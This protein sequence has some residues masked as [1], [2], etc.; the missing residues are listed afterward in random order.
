MQLPSRNQALPAAPLTQRRFAVGATELLFLV[1]LIGICAALIG[2]AVSWRPPI[3]VGV[4]SE[5]LGG[6]AF[7]DGIYPREQHPSGFYYRWTNGASLVQL[8][9]AANYASAYRVVV[10]LRSDRPGDPVPLSLR[11]DTREL[12]TASPGPALRSYQLLLAPAADGE[13]RLNLATLPFVAPG[14]PRPLGV[15]LTRL[16][17]HP[18]SRTPLPDIGLVTGGLLLLWAWMRLRGASPR[19]TLN[20]CTIVSLSLVA[21]F[22]LYRPAPLPFGLLALLSLAAIIVSITLARR[23]AAQTGLAALSLIVSFSGV[24]WPSW[25]SDDAFISFRYAQNLVA[26]NGLVYNPGERVEGYTNFLWTMLSAV[27]IALG[28]DIAFWS[29]AAGVALGLALLLLCY[30][31]AARLIGPAWGLAAALIVGTSQSVLLYTA[32]GSG[33]ETGL[34]S[35]LVLAGVA[36]Y[37]GRHAGWAGLVFALA[38]L[39]RPEGVLVLGLTAVYQLVVDFFPPLSHAQERRPVGEGRV[40]QTLLLVG[41]FLLI[42]APYMLWRVTYYGDLLPNTFY[43]KTG[44]GLRQALRGLAYAGGFAL[45]MGGPLL[46][47]V[48]LP[49]LR[50]WRVALRSWRGYLLLIVLVYSAYI[51]AVG[52]DH[53]RGERF[54][55]PLVPLIAILMA[56]GMAV[57]VGGNAPAGRLY[58]GRVAL[59]VMLV[60]G[61]AAALLRTMPFD[62]TMRG[63]DESVWIWREIGWW[64]ADNT[65]PDASIAASGAGAVAYYGQRET[66]DM[67][68]LNDRHIARIDVAEMGSGVAG[69]EKR[70]PAYVLNERRPTY[71]PQI[72]DEYFGGAAGLR[73]RYR[74]ITVTTRSGRRIQLWERTPQVVS[75]Q[76]DRMV[77]AMTR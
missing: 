71:I 61:G 76:P 53:F 54:F 70:D 36:L 22:E 48:G 7:S 8:R 50:G 68:G 40:W 35:V 58:R 67:L 77:G 51:V 17:L 34:F 4:G 5:D 66:I 31:L 18:L 37:L 33:L 55:V 6:P 46:L 25:L 12:A 27:P 73:D 9:G 41:A 65:P 59:V 2:P 60:I 43:A 10:D 3:V 29:L 26:G 16:E 23:P 49:W 75:S 57:A 69:H 42:A 62:A 38:A 13:L 28:G 52:G 47:I 14:N 56:D 45:T 44:G 74:L 72:W 30:G 24:I 15:Q 64:M 20:L 21:G 19:A 39:T 63:L 11:A 1:L 32:R